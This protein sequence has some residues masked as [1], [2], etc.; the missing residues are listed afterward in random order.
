MEKQIKLFLE[1]L[2]KDK[3]LSKNTL[4]SYNRDILQSGKSCLAY[5]DVRPLW[6]IQ[7]NCR[8]YAKGPSGVLTMEW[9][10]LP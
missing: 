8:T 9:G 4:Q 2:Q 5:A 7:Y 3:K 10:P 1:F 6:A